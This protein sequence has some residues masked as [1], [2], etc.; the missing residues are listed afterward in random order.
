MGEIND[1]V[2][3]LKFLVPG[4]IA[5][6]VFYGLT[7]HKRLSAFERVIQALVFTLFVQTAFEFTKHFLLG[8]GT[9][10]EVGPW[11]ELSVTFW[12]VVTALS[13]G[14]ALAWI[15][16]SNRLHQALQQI[17]ITKQTSYPSEW[18]GVLAE[19]ENYVI[20]HLQD[21]RRI[22][23][24]PKEWP[25]SFDEGH[26]YLKSAIWLDEES[27]VPLDD[28]EGILIPAERV[29]YVEILR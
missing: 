17:G 24:W 10:F 14:A 18:Y 28:S 19:S 8:M 22:S 27:D 15:A 9:F 29:T 25:S 6:W 12:Y 5:A 26:F 3:L 23:G 4:L 21:E 1:I 7:P 16:N 13:A 11:N 2:E 20:L